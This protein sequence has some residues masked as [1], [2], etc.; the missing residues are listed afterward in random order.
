MIDEKKSTWD[1]RRHVTLH[2]EILDAGSFDK[3][4]LESRGTGF[5]TPPA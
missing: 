5:P 3:V 2:V 1:E 4:I